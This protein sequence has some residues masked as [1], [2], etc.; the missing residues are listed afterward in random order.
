MW[1]IWN[2][3]HLTERRTGY[4]NMCGLMYFCVRIWKREAFLKCTLHANFASTCTH[5][6]DWDEHA[7]TALPDTKMITSMSSTNPR[8]FRR[9]WESRVWSGIPPM[10]T[11]MIISHERLG[12]EIVRKNSS[13][14]ID[15]DV[16]YSF[17]IPGRIFLAK[18]AIRKRN[19]WSNTAKNSFLRFLCRGSEPRRNRKTSAD[20]ASDALQ[21]LLDQFVPESGR[22]LLFRE[23]GSL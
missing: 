12:D 7:R 1:A 14:C 17:G 23:K 2:G 20:R 11:L 18:S 16:D 5:F 6:P 8:S 19:P 10:D 9:F 21:N 13:A 3:S 15:I 22:E 4:Q